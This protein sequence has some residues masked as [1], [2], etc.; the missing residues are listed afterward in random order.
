MKHNTTTLNFLLLTKKLIV[1]EA[2]TIIR[3]KLY[4]VGS[5]RII[6]QLEGKGK[7]NISKQIREQI[8]LKP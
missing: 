3:A 5:A 2:K 6:N 4:N 7:R 8:S 1:F